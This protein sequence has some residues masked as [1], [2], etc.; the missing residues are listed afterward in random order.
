M[1]RKVDPKLQTDVGQAV[2]GLARHFRVYDSPSSRH[3]LQVT[4][5]DCA[6]I[7]GKVFVVD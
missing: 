5:A 1:F 4:F 7:P 6:F 2:G 3:E